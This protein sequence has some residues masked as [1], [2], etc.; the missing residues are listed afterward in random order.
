MLASRP[1]EFAAGG[2]PDSGVS[3]ID[4]HGAKCPKHRLGVEVRAWTGNSEV[5]A[6]DHYLQIT[7][8]HFAEAAGASEIQGGTEAGAASA[9]STSQAVAPCSE[10][11]SASSEIAGSND[12]V[13]QDANSCEEDSM[14]DTGLEHIQESSEKQ[15]V[16]ARCGAESGAVLPL[17]SARLPLEL[18]EIIAKWSRLPAA[19]QAA[20]LAIVRVSG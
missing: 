18:A 17:G 5:V 1:H 9:R 3:D 11:K 16:A 4:F 13:R 10:E 12:G 6:R 14:G 2:P 15:A 19:L 7:A 8:E 20:I